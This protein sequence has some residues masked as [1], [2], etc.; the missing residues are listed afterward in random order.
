MWEPMARALGWPDKPLGWADVATLRDRGRRLV[1]LRPPGMGRASSSGTR[2]RA[3]ATR[4][5]SP[6]VA[7]TY[8]GAGKTR[9]LRAGGRAHAAG[10]FVKRVQTSVVHYGRSTGFFADED[11][12]ARPRLP[13]GGRALR[14]PGGGE[15]ARPALPGQAVPGGRRV[16]ARGHVLVRSPVRDPRPAR[17][18]RP[19]CARRRSASAPS[20]SRRERQRAALARFG[21]RPADPP[22][23]LGA[24]LDAAHGVDP[25]QPQNVLP[26]PPVA[27][28][29][30]RCSTRFEQREAAGVHHVRD[31]HLGLDERR[32]PAAGQGRRAR[33]PGGPARRATPCACCSSRARRAGSPSG[34]SRSRTAR[35]AP[36]RR[37]STRAS[38]TAARRSTTRCWRRCPPAPGASRA[39][40]RARW[41]C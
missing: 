30:A 33:V 25:A 31:R 1:A 5:R 19:R 29:R 6:C 9:D 8:A 15:R 26:N 38:P 13:L 3:T 22:V 28:T 2:T 39:A 7:A 32:A 12:H 16:P 40:R 17:A 37:R 41:S 20:C 4:A 27:V 36:G 24:P 10:P 21:F 23:A 14:E 18:S 34:R 11:V 35:A